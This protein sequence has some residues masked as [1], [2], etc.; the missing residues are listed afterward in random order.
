M[1]QIKPYPNKIWQQNE[2]I[3]RYEMNDISSTLYEITSDYNDFFTQFTSADDTQTAAVRV[4]N[5]IDSFTCHTSFADD[6]GLVSSINDNTASFG[7]IGSYY[8]SISSNEDGITALE[9]KCERIEK[10]ITSIGNRVVNMGYGSAGMVSVAGQYASSAGQSASN[11]RNWAISSGLVN[12]ED[13]SARYYADLAKEWAISSQPIET[14]ETT[15]NDQN[16]TVNITDYSAKHYADELLKYVNTILPWDGTKD[17]VIRN[18]IIPGFSTDGGKK[19][20][21]NIDI[22]K[23]ID[24]TLISSISTAESVEASGLFSNFYTAP[25]EVSSQSRIKL[26]TLGS[27]L[28][29]YSTYNSP[30]DITDYPEGTIITAKILVDKPIAGDDISSITSTPY[31]PSNILTLILT[32]PQSHKYKVKKNKKTYTYTCSGWCTGAN[33]QIGNTTVLMYIDKLIIRVKDE[34]WATLNSWSSALDEMFS[35]TDDSITSGTDTTDAEN[36]NNP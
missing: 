22:G 34:F 3:D 16:V 12:E 29:N 13:Y 20:I 14:G 21:F 23:L 31:Y 9:K 4:K 36:N 2:T 18:T 7:S 33:A 25:L 19:L 35:S 24:D 27:V 1:P 6:D 32:N 26:T 11:A 8:D 28:M 5:Y 17:I 30:F 10:F 15:Q